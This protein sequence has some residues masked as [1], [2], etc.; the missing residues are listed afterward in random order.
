MAVNWYLEVLKKYATFT[1]RA[2]RT[3]FWTYTLVNTVIAL[4]VLLV[5]IDGSRGVVTDSLLGRLYILYGVATLVPSLA[6]AVRRLHDTGRGGLWVL[7]QFVPFANFVLI[8]ILLDRGTMGPNIYGPDP[9]YSSPAPGFM[10]PAQ[11]VQSAP[12]GVRVLLVTHAGREIFRMPM[13]L[14]ATCSIGRAAGS[15]IVLQD[16]KASSNHALLEV[17]S[18]GTVALRDLGSTNGTFVGQ[19]RI[20]AAVR[21]QSGTTV[22]FGDTSLAL[23]W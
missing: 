22:R 1:G 14:G 18:D 20:T 8:V 12:V 23:A 16:S 17:L 10:P 4:V 15:S 6:V 21:I 19:S 2:H 3:E 11:A 7:L 5:D 9:H 13:S